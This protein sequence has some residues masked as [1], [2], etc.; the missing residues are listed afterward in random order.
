MQEIRG[1]GSDLQKECA[2]CEADFVRDMDDDLNISGALGTVF[3][4]IREVNRQADQDEVGAE[5]A[6]N[7][8]TL[9]DKL[10]AVTGLFAGVR[11]E[12]VPEEILALVDARQKARRAKDFAASDAI[13]DQLAAAG[14]VVEDTPDGPRVKKL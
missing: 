13:R 2:A 3:T 10:N 5:G 9:L 11:E 14:W 7:A 6:K 1:E 8:L 12:A 4:F